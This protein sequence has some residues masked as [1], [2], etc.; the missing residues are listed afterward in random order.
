MPEG[1]AAGEFIWLFDEEDDEELLLTADDI[2]VGNEEVAGEFNE[3]DWDDGGGCRAEIRLWLNKD[4]GNPNGFVPG[5][6]P[7]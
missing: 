5:M 3:L 6:A 2:V 4:A 1:F 7:P